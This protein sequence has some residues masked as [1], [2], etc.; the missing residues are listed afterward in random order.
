ML[1]LG[2][3]DKELTVTDAWVRATQGVS[4]GTSWSYVGRFAYP[5]TYAIPYVDDQFIEV[6]IGGELASGPERGHAVYRFEGVLR[7]SSAAD[8]WCG[9]QLAPPP[10]PTPAEPPSPPPPE[11]PSAP[12]WPTSDP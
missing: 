10:P 9:Q 1:N 12:T 2:A 5:R 6:H 7:E 4:R 3:A 8:T 11:R